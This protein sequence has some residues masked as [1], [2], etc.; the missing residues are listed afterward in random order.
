VLRQLG[1]VIRASLR[2]IDFASR[3]GGDEFALLLADSEGGA[4]RKVV[5]RIV[6]A[7]R[8]MPWG[9]LGEGMAVTLS[10]GLCESADFN[11]SSELVR[12]ADEALYGAKDA[13]RDRIHVWSSDRA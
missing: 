12:R 8:A 13:G 5:E 6:Q 9:Q 1:N 11:D 2:D 3:L 7:V 10:V 4:A